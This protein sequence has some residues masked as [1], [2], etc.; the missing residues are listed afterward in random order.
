[1][2]LRRRMFRFWPVTLAVL[3]IFGMAASK[4]L[5]VES[6]REKPFPENSLDRGINGEP[7][8]LN[9]QNFSSN[10]SATVLRDVGEGL[11]TYSSGG[12]IVAGVAES[13]QI[14]DDNRSFT[15]KIR[16]SATWS[17]GMPI[18]P[19]DFV[20]A[21]RGLI[22][23]RTAAHNAHYLDYV[24]NAQKIRAS[25]L[26]VE[27]L[28][29]T[30]I[31][32][33]E[34]RIELEASTPFFLELLAHPSLFPAY[35]RDRRVNAFIDVFNGAYSIGSMVPGSEIILEKNSAYWNSDTVA[36]DQVVYHIV[37]EASEFNRFRAGEID[38]TANIA[39][40]DFDQAR[41]SFPDELR[42]SPSLG[43]YYYGY[44][45][46]NPKFAEN[47][48]LREALSLAIDRELLVERVSGR[49]EEPAYNWVPPGVR[50]YR[51]MINR[52]L[53]L[54]KDERELRA[55]E[56]YRAAGFSAE[57]PVSVEVRYNTSDVQ[58]RI[59]LAI[60][61]MWNQVLGVDATLVNEEFAVLLS[62]IRQAEVTE[63]FRLS[64]TADFNAADAF[65][66]VFL[67]ENPSNMTQFSNKGFDDLV[68]SARQESNPDTR[69]E[70]LM[71]AEE[72]LV[73]SHAVIPLYFYV[74]KHLV[75]SRVAGWVDNPI[76]VHLSKYL[77]PNPTE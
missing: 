73:N 25:E 75:S 17:N 1:M 4:I 37:S 20:Y 27:S 77:R 66:Q 61:E 32:P 60:Q 22:D 9:P 33:D 3:I 69:A 45:L 46:T 59:A 36:Y 47:R 23:P 8:S 12:E 58:R 72:L 26:S 21:F 63:I 49:G 67:S 5:V 40:T 18:I 19:S 44:N 29:V 13:W 65:L 39:S 30:E 56:L 54:P 38:I 71:D 24:K 15:F 10:Q 55:R 34:L 35:S 57:R 53:A 48:E 16:A 31:S 68:R 64:W 76:D 11:V 42:I 14:A 62:N 28:G 52:D 7:E 74:N 70:L 6:P 51:P 41:K 50:N 43:V 2:T